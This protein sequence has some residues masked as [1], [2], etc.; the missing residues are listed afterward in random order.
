MT[1]MLL[2]LHVCSPG[3]L[4][5]HA[6]VMTKYQHLNQFDLLLSLFFRLC[7]LRWACFAAASGGGRWRILPGRGS[8]VVAVGW[9]IVGLGGGALLVLL[10]RLLPFNAGLEAGLGRRW[11]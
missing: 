10:F 9:R 6:C 1:L 11:L 2:T 8:L 4:M 7:C 5:C 3:H